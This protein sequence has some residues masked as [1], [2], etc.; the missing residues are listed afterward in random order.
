MPPLQEFY[1]GLVL[2]SPKILVNKKN[3]YENRQKTYF[4]FFFEY[5][6]VKIAV[7]VKILV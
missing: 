5:A 6:Q 4:Y 2:R 1:S 7:K 3:Y